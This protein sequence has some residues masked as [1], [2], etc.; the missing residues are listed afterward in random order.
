MDTKTSLNFV[1]I[2]DIHISE[3][4]QSWGS[5]G[6]LSG[7]LL[8]DTIK[9]VNLIDDL[10]FVL[11]TGD[12]LD[13]A[14]AGELERFT[15]LLSTLQK[16]WHFIP[17]NH[18]GFI[19]P[20]LPGAYKP[21]EAIPVID[22]RMTT[23][24]PIAQQARWSRTVKPGVQ[25]IGLDSRMA[26]HW[27]GVIEVEQLD[28]LKTELDTHRDK[29]VIIAVHHPLHHLGEHNA[30]GWWR[31]FVCSNGAEVEGLLAQY[32][33]VKMVF[34][35]HHHANQIQLRQGRLHVNTASLTGY[36]CT[37]RTVHLEM[38]NPGWL[39]EI[40]TR[41]VADESLLLRAREM[42][43]QSNVAKEF[44]PG[45]PEAWLEFVV[46]RPQDR[47]YSGVIGSGDERHSY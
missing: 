12:V 35:G 24:K 38:S 3:Q 25:L 27:G 32:P 30:Q 9:Q 31:N 6:D 44:V 29:L 41:T 4:Q 37:Y 33:N 28:W 17:G 11:I 23:P 19:D 47:H 36:P 18:D 10:D 39:A 15:R 5:L 46:G 16:P 26:D 40:E 20:D 1:H 14:T 13:E 34:A 2:T 8:A 43:A 7:R 21:H 22:P 45:E 42:L